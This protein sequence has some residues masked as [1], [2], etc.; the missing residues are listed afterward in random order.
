MELEDF[1]DD[2]NFWYKTL[3]PTE[4][5]HTTGE[6]HATVLADCFEDSLSN[7]ADKRRLH[8]NA[9]FS[10]MTDSSRSL[11]CNYSLCSI[12]C[13]PAH[14][15]QS[16]IIQCHTM[17]YGDFQSAAWMLYPPQASPD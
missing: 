6:L 16:I 8:N 7:I 12:T 14:E 13:P 9:L 10:T 4:D 2:E 5:V 15:I 3:L 1:T 17:Q 11:V